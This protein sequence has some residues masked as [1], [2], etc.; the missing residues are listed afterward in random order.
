VKTI[1]IELTDEEKEAIDELLAVADCDEKSIF[2]LGSQIMQ[3]AIQ[4]ITYFDRQR[5]FIAVGAIVQF[6]YTGEVLGDRLK[7]Y[8]Q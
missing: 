1:T 6:K 2:G 3:N 7:E 8:L 4:I 5:S